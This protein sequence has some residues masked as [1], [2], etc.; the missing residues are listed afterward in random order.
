MI[1]GVDFDNTIVNYAG[2]FH[3]AAVHQGLVA[4]DS[5]A[6]KTAI[7]D[8]L[9][10]RGDERLWTELQGHVYGVA[11]EEAKPFAGVR[12]FFR[13]CR[14]RSIP[15]SII[16]HRTRRPYA[17]PEVDLHAA[18]RTWI[19]SNLNDASGPLI[20]E[21]RIH[22]EETKNDKLARIA[23]SGCTHFIDDLPEFLTETGFPAN[24]HRLL[25][26]PEDRHRERAAGIERVGAWDEIA[27]AMLG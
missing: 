23:D 26:D 4:A 2:I 9:R 15:V 13:E 8:A 7:R 6:S 3:R 22:F 21:G 19:A 5:P 20:A 14:A 25:F 18:G 24:V 27:H 1:I 16:S 12:E 11:I 17:G 10:D